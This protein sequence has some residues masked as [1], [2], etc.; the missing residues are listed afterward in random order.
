[1]DLFRLAWKNL[2]GNAF[3]S[4]AVFSCAALIAGLAL[5]ATFI[6]RGAEASLRSNLDRMGADILVVPWGTI[7]EKIEGIR[8]M[9]A[10]IEGWI[11]LTYMDKI[12]AIDGVAEVSPQLYLGLID[13]SPYSPYP[14]MHLVAYDPETD[15]T[16]RPWL[17]DGRAAVLGDGEAI[18]GAHVILPDGGSELSLHGVQLQMVDRLVKTDTT[19]DST[20]FVNFDTAKRMEIWSQSYEYKP[21]KLQP[22]AASAIMVKLNLDADPHTVALDI[23]DKAKGVTPLENPGMFQAERRQMVGV[24][25][26][27]LGALTGIWVL[28]LVF[29]GL[30]FSIAVNERRFEIGVLRAIGFPSR[31]ILKTLLFESTTLA[32]AGSFAGV[33]VT[34]SSFNVLG[35]Q[36]TS[37]IS[38]PLSIPTPAGLIP[39][40]VGG[41]SLALVSVTIAAFIPAWRI[42]QEEAS[43]SMRS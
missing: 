21:I 2:F 30:L 43:V 28:V 40:I 4:L 11:P 25:N 20:L 34:L 29:M 32:L 37:A 12:A 23:L 39:L 6:V 17:V 16:L 38:L 5:T 9:S 31:S 18:A 7:T 3:R 27:L 10:A 22:G 33:L 36:F 26:M 14:D 13:D 8:L 15:F 19:I 35:A 41:Q 1:V 42:S 24:L